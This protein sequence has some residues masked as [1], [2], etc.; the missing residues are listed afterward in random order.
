LWQVPVGVPSF[1][2][3]AA[4]RCC[5]PAKGTIPHSPY[6]HQ[7]Y[8]RAL[9]K[10]LDCQASMWHVTDSPLSSRALR[11]RSG[12]APGQNP[13]SILSSRAEGAE[14]PQPRDPW[15]RAPGKRTAFSA[16]TGR[17]A[18]GTRSSQPMPGARAA[19]DT[20]S[21]PAPGKRRRALAGA[22]G[23]V[24]RGRARGSL[25]GGA[26]GPTAPVFR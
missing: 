1:A 22:L 2:E 17:Q 23:G 16:R 19:G 13:R 10:R 11:L 9:A 26:G 8:G 24:G 25:G 4:R 18:H 5:R 20:L 6:R 7:R 3:R 14:P 12:Q 21:A 15:V